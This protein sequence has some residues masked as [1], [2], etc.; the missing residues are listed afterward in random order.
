MTRRTLV[1]VSSAVVL[2]LLG[3]I[4]IIALARNHTTNTNQGVATT[5]SVS[6]ENSQLSSNVSL[7]YFYSSTYEAKNGDYAVN[8]PQTKGVDWGM[9]ID[10]LSAYMQFQA[11]KGTDLGPAE[12]QRN[13]DQNCTRD[14]HIYES[15]R[16][17]IAT[18]TP[19]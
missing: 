9:A 18:G 10:T 3:G 15:L 8:C 1:I 11:P 14:M 2:F 5:D 13:F 6:S 17:Q 19:Q 7:S 4:I 16:S 12:I